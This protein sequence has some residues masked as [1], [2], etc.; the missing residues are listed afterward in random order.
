[1]IDHTPD[2]WSLDQ[3]HWKDRAAGLSGR[4]LLR[5]TLALPIPLS[6]H[7]K[8]FE[9]LGR[10]RTLADGVSLRHWP[11]GGPGASIFA[12]AQPQRRILWYHGGGFVVGSPRSY[13]AMLSQL[14]LLANAEVIAPTYRLA[15]EHKFPGAADDAETAA[16]AAWDHGTDLGPLI[17][18]GDSAGGNLACV[19]L[20]HLLA[21]DKRP[22]GMVLAS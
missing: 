22:A 1:M 12:P 21:Q 3:R 10:R 5:P 17:L 6:V 20:A 8:T 15:P 18:G 11:E 4:Y 19:A 13:G 16:L 7:R 2:S 14:A 9:F